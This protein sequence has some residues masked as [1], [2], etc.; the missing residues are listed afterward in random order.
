MEANEAQELQEHAEHGAESKMRPVAFTMSLVAVLVALTTVLGHRTHT[1]AVLRQAKASDT[2]N[3]YQA[4]KNRAYDTTLVNDILSVVTIDDKDGAKKIAKGYSDH[5]EKW[6]DDLKEEEKEAQGLEQ[7][8]RE[9][10]HQAKFYDLG[11]ALLEIGL[12]VSS[13]TLLTRSRIYWYLGI[14]ASVGGLASV[15]W[16]LL[17]H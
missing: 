13:V 12:V 2:W 15:L 1:E 5:K 9:A 3:E 4:K 16:G 10:E 17:V 6:A 8:V 11:E 14:V 7:E